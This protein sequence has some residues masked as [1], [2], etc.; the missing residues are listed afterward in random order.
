MRL[1]VP[2]SPYAPRVTSIL[3][4]SLVHQKVLHIYGEIGEAQQKPLEGNL[5]IHHDKDGQAFPPTSWP[6]IESYFKALVHLSPGW[7]MIRLDFTPS[8]I[9]SNDS[10]PTIHTSYLRLNYL[11]LNDVPPLQLV[12]LAGKDSPCTFD[13]MPERIQ[14]EGNDLSAATRKFRMAAHLWQAFT[15][16][17]MHRNKFGRRC[18]RFEEEWQTGT[19]SMMDWQMGRMRNETKVHLVRTEQTVAELQALEYA[20]QYGPASKK[21]ELYSIATNAIKKY[22]NARPG[23]KLY[24][25]ALLIDAHWDPKV[26]TIR[27]HAALGGGD[28]ELQLAIFGAQ[29]LQSYPSSIEEVVPA[30]SD[31][32]RTDTKYVANDCGESGSNWEAAN[33]GIG[34]HLHEVGHLF[35]CPHQ[36]SGVMLRDYVR[37]NR[38]FLLREPYSTRTKLPGLRLCRME[39]EC[40]WHRLDVLRFRYHPCFRLPSDEPL[41]SQD[42]SITCFPIGDGNILFAASTGIPHIEVRLDGEDLCKQSFEYISAGSRINALPRQVRLSEAEIR[43]KL[44][45]DKKKSKIRLEIF[46]GGSRSI[47]IDDIANILSKAYM[48]TLPQIRQAPKKDEGLT[49]NTYNNVMGLGQ[50]LAKRQGFKSLKLG[51]SQQQGTQPVEV[52]LESLT[53]QTKLLTS[54]K[55]YSGFALDGMEFCYEDGHSQLF[56][57]RGGK[58]GGDELFLDTRRGE[59]ILGFYVRA[60]LWVDGIE[61]LT[62]LGRRSGYFG[63]I[64]GGSAHT[65]MAPRGYSIAG[66]SGTCGQWIDG[67]QIIITR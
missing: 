14:R 16:E 28:G 19:L 7:N 43:A 47:K 53:L 67:F 3:N 58:P 36:E 34:A 66:V 39:D 18:F 60:G 50:N 49:M 10:A 42:D 56:G 63:N 17:Q 59:T 13:A 29:A 41:I 38:T 35:G 52:I 65:L 5:T 24:V 61:V 21:G 8:R 2:T 9:G 40:N 11:P 37:L 15:A 22:F 33:I 4:E 31:C 6:V 20:Q 55:I 45:E 26:G 51:A 23:Q 1:P 46:C 57:K 27:G 30:F 62:T 44:P 48:M 32:T 64:H 54:I 25:A 12:I